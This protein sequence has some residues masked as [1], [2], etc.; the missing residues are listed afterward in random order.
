MSA[1]RICRR[2]HECP[3]WPEGPCGRPRSTRQRHRKGGW[4]PHWCPECDERR[5]QGIS[6]SLGNIV[7]DMKRRDD[8]KG[9]GKP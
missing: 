5:I 9:E 1:C 4:S 2:V 8:G 7:A 6:A 3:G